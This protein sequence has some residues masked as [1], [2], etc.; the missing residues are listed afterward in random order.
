MIDGLLFWGSCF[1]LLAKCWKLSTGK[2][3]V[4]GALGWL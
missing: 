2:D 3:R 1:L 4:L